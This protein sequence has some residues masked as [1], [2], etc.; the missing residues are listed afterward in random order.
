[1]TNASEPAKANETYARDFGV[2]S[3]LAMPPSRK[4]AVITCMDAGIDPTA[5]LASR[6]A[7]R[8]ILSAMPAVELMTP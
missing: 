5:S 8:T 1:M 7:R 6:K 4:V 3:E 2:K